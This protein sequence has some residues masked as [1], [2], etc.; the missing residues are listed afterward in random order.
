MLTV[1]APARP[2]RLL[3]C[4]FQ[5]TDLWLV[6]VLFVHVDDIV[7]DATQRHCMDEEQAIPAILAETCVYWNGVAGATVLDHGDICQLWIFQQLQHMAISQDTSFRSSFPVRL[8]PSQRLYPLNRGSDPWWIITTVNLF[9]NIKYRY[10]FGYFEVV[11]VSPRFGLMLLSMCISVIFIVAD[12]L[13]V[14]SALQIGGLNPF[15]KI[16]FVFK[17]L[18]D[19][20]VLHDFKTALDKLTDYKM[21]RVQN[22]NRPHLEME[23]IRRPTLDEEALASDSVD[24][25]IS[26]EQ[27]FVRV[28]TEFGNH[29]P[30][31]SHVD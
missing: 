21:R 12:V 20:I 31:T 19:T 8:R 18:T 26:P 14:T 1:A 28:G 17:C 13:A 10:G 2:P 22:V 30:F 25:T 23:R 27:Q 3:L 29:K 16:A 24:G 4:L 9:W 5:P 11:K 7:M 6:S 15:W